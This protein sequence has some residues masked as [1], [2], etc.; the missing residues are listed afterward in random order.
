[1]SSSPNVG[2]Q[3]MSFGDNVASSM[4]TRGTSMDHTRDLGFL[5]DATLSDFFQRPIKIAEYQWNTNSDIFTTF[6]PWS[7]YFEDPQVAKKIANYYL[8][9]CNL[10]VKMLINGNAFYYGRAIA[11][12]EP[13]LTSDDFSLV[14]PWTRADIVRGSQ[15]MH[16]YLNPTTSQGGDLELPFFFKKN[17]LSIPDKEWSQLGSIVL[18]SINPLLHANGGTTP[19]SISVFAWA[20][21]VSYSIPTAT[22]P[23]SDE[24][25]MGVVSKPASTVARYAGSLATLP[26]IGSFAR[27]TEIGATAVSSIAKI[28]GYSAPINLNSSI[29]LPRARNS[30][31]TTDDMY[32]GCK[33]TVDSKQELTIDP[34]TTGIQSK[35]ELTICSIAERESYLT[36]FQWR[37]SDLPETLLFNS[38]VDPGIHATLGDGEHHL[39]SAAV[40]VLPFEYWRGTMR[41]RFQIVSSEYHKGRIRILYDPVAG[42]STA[43]YNTHYTKIHDI[44]SSKDFTFDVGWAQ[45]TPY[46]RSI[47]IDSM[48]SSL[49]YGSTPLLQSDLGN[50]VLSVFILNPLTTASTVVS[51]IEINVFVSM[52][53]DFEVAQPSRRLDSVRYFP[54]TPLLTTIPEMDMDCCET[55]V[56][57]PSSIGNVAEVSIAEKDTTKLFF[58]EVIG[59]FRQLLKRS[60]YH[61]RITL[62]SATDPSIVKVSRP[63]FPNFGGYVTGPGAGQSPIIDLNNGRFYLYMHTTLLNYLALAFVGRRGSV[64]WTLD[65]TRCER[66]STSSYP[67]SIV[68]SRSDS[69]SLDPVS[70]SYVSSETRGDYLAASYN[71]SEGESS[72][73]TSL[74]ATMVNPIHA[75]E[76]PYY[77]NQRF[78]ENLRLDNIHSLNIVPSYTFRVSLPG[79]T[80]RPNSYVDTYVSAGEDFNLFYFNAM[81]I[82]FYEP[83][84]PDPSPG[85]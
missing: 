82:V 38:R 33:L 48:N 72:M 8:L 51:D 40:A 66:P 78:T 44:S 18:T 16:V 67:N 47:G 41:F 49:W 70:Y 76:C 58:G 5:N 80:T 30:L 10:H 19:L 35:D 57:D 26:V 77:Q 53:D 32:N 24:Y 15:K 64:R 6:D 81:P 52:L 62:P 54:P 42:S 69:Y 39:T 13:L 12:Y 71:M 29:M 61:E 3:T 60:Y 14:R 7:L 2:S 22:V 65:F 85:P 45:T 37:V 46:R 56:S 34:T 36:T 55:P 23:E 74:C 59:S 21:N 25:T 31:A 27:A 83:Y 79:G 73:G 28:F 4:D 11:C 50:G 63:A 75:V 20:T 43:S 17:C 1:M 84:A 68:V 9:K